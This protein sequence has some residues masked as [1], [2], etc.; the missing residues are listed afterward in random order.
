MDSTTV[1]SLLNEAAATIRTLQADKTKL[2]SA[3]NE[4][5]RRDSAEEVVS[6]MDAR[7][8]GD[9]QA[10]H[11]QKVASVLASNK[12]LDLIKQALRLTPT[13]MSF[14]KVSEEAETGTTTSK[15]VEYLRS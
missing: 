8:L 1:Q 9:V 5:K 7:G 14:A 15:L 11:K 13:D 4:Y 6:L 3:L 2:A 12:D 10:P